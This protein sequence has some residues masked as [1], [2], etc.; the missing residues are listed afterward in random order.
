MANQRALEFLIRLT[1]NFAKVWAKEAQAYD[2]INKRMEGQARGYY[3]RMGRGRE[4]LGIRSEKAIQREIQLTQAA[5]NRLARSGTLSQ[6]ELSRAA[7]ATRTK[8]KG[9]NAELGKTTALQKASKAAKTAI[10]VG[11]GLAVAGTVVKGPVEKAMEFDLRMRH[12]ANTA[13]N[14][15]DVAGRLAGAKE[16]EAKINAAADKSGGTREQA[17]DTLDKYI[18]SGIEIDQALAMLPGTVKAATASNS[19]GVEM[20]GIATSAVQTFKISSDDASNIFNMAKAGADAGGFEV[21]DMAQHLPSQMAAA[22]MSGMSGKDDLARIIALN[23]VGRTTAGSADEAG[24]NVKNLLLKVNSND[25]YKDA[26]KFEKSTIAAISKETGIGVKDMVS[27]VKNKKGKVVGTEFDLHK[28][29]SAQKG[30]GVDSISAFAAMINAQLAGNKEYQALQKEIAGKAA[31]DPTRKET[32]GKMSQLSL[33]TSIG[34]LVQ[35]AQALMP[36]IAMMND[37]KRFDDITKSVMKGDDREA[38]AIETA[39]QTVYSSD[40]AQIERAIQ[41][42]NASLKAAYDGFSGVLGGVAQGFSSIATSYP[43]LTGGATLATKALLAF[44]SVAG[45][46]SMAMGAKNIIPKIL[47]RG[48]A[49]A[50]AVAAKGVVAAKGAAA[51]KPVAA[52]AGDAVKVAAAKG[53]ATAKPVAAAAGDAAKAAAAAAAPAVKATT[54][55]GRVATAAAKLS[56]MSGVGKTL[57]KGSLPINLAMGAL[58]VGSV[59]A[60]DQGNKGARVAEA[61]SGIAGSMAG[62]AVG[63]QIG[64]GIGTVLLPGLG[65]VIGGAIGGIGGALY[66]SDA[67]KGLYH[68]AFGNPNASQFDPPKA[69]Q[70][71]IAP[72]PQDVNVKGAITSTILVRAEAGTSATLTSTVTQQ[73]SVPGIKL[74]PGNTNPGGRPRVGA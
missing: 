68:Y 66:G 36:L 61:G 28:Y 30:K 67:G 9:L 23:Q 70:A 24:N 33:G 47:G 52:A 1:S 29:M 11:A 20:A 13:Y 5:Y 44:A 60:D 25:T 17:A 6:K 55:A 65:T 72:P 12:L 34:S 41:A 73:P 22:V 42:N 32:I 71:L 59:L 37:P 40:S 45:I 64:A 69:A 31:D 2:A 14:Q 62:G 10:A 54:T 56:A 21:K 16:M 19:E 50:A 46:V 35:D 49:A 39:F 43:A 7:D 53:A 8:I 38:P 48:G 4:V 74:N 15:R 57:V 3:E 51:A 27:E 63:A 58:E 18:S 26:S